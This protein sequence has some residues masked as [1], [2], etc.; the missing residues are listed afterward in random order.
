VKRFARTAVAAALALASGTAAALGLGQIELKSRLGE[1]LLAEI[2]I[3]SNDPAELERLRAGLA[4]PETFARI[5]LQPPDGVVANLQF[6]SALDAQGRPVIRVTS[7]QPIEQPLLTF[8]VEVDWGQ[9]R[10][11][12][13]Y[14]TLVDAP[15][16][17]SAPLQPPIEAPVVA[18]SNTIVRESQAEAPAQ[19]PAETAGQPADS[20]TAEAGTDPDAIAPLE[21]QPAPVAAAPV[22]PPSRPFPAQRPAEYGAVQQGETLSQIAERLGFAASLDQT[23]IALLNANPDAFINGNIHLL[24]QGAVLRVPEEEQVR[25]VARAEAVAQVREQTRAWRAATAP[26]PQPVL[27]GDAPA[28]AAADAPESAPAA[29]DA[30]LEIVPPGASDASQAGTQSGMSAGGE[31]DVMRQQ[32]QQTRETLAAR[33]AELAELKSR[34]AELEKL[35]SDQQKLL[36]MKDNELT[37]V[38]QRLAQTGEAEQAARAS[39]MPWVL[40]GAALLLLALLGGWWMRR[41]PAAPVFRAPS[42]ERSPLAAA[43]PPAASTADPIE[44]GKRDEPA[45]AQLSAPAPAPAQPPASASASAQPPA[46]APTVPVAPAKPAPPAPPAAP[47]WHAA[48]GGVASPGVP[49]AQE[50]AF[51]PDAPG[52]ERIELAR[53]YLDL[54][55]RDSARQLLGEVVIN[56]DHGS[57]QQAARMLRELE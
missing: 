8:L 26:A 51:D 14:S 25:A 33:D 24:R 29:G 44:S 57:R 43:F 32:L 47:T 52:R 30:R 1:P 41:R 19:T 42:P 15:R 11:V 40:G 20:A 45:A 37:A 55:D 2:P 6:V 46:P 18:P 34:V 23:M 21:T 3:I 12:R 22:V 10:L 31:G 48:P 13:E 17:V 36:E 54:G 4:S 53:A 50:P 39:G 7:S 28:Q 38:Q 49:E 9:G 35:Q 5:G 27:A 16:T 56:G